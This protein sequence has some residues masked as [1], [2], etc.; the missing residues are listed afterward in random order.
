MEMSVEGAILRPEYA[1]LFT[2]EERQ[3]AHDG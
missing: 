2:D 1:A 3:I